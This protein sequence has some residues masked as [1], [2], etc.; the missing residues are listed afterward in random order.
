MYPS[1]IRSN[2]KNIKSP[3]EGD[4]VIKNGQG[5]QPVKGIEYKFEFHNG[6]WFAYTPQADGTFKNRKVSEN[7]VIKQQGYSSWGSGSTTIS[8]GGESEVANTPIAAN[9]VYS[10]YEQDENGDWFV[11][12]TEGGRKRKKVGNAS[13]IAKLNSIYVPKT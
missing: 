2:I 10:D 11:K 7:Y 9:L 4:S 1:Q 8:S 5:A 3:E 13:V 12:S 6:S